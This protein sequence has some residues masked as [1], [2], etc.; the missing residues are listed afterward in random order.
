MTSVRSANWSRMVLI[1]IKLAPL[2]S[3]TSGGSPATKRGCRVCAMFVAAVTLTVEPTCNFSTC[4]AANSA[5][6][7]P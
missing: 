4:L 5:Y 1:P 7:M 6:A 3:M 2:L